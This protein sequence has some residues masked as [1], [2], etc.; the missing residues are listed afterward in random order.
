MSDACLVAEGLT[1]RYF[2]KGRESAREFD[3]VSNV[4]L[5]LMPGE[6]VVLMGRSGGG[7]STL[8]NMLA[9][10]LEPSEGTVTFEGKN[11]YAMGDEERSRLRNESFGVM[12]QGQTPLYSLS[13]IQ[14]VTLPQLMYREEAGI[15]GRAMDLL[16]ELGIKPL[17]DAYPEELSGGELRRMA[18][19]RA[20]LGKPRILLADEPTGDLD[21]ESTRMVLEKLQAAAQAGAAVLIATHDQATI[22]YADRVLNIDG[23]VLKEAHNEKGEK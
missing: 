1:K 2:R 6:L 11:L 23:G 16:D 21:D 18:I 8:L 15:E 7:K 5:E 22:S 20:L 9:G 13:V 12:P 17:A 14:N 4:S 3:A 10:L 19:A